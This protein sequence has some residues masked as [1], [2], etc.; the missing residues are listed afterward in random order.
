[1]TALSLA[2]KTVPM[3]TQGFPHLGKVTR[4]L[5]DNSVFIT[6]IRFKLVIFFQSKRMI[7]EEPLGIFIVKKDW[8]VLKTL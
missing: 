7:F 6:L 5:K 4:P 2:E 1:M 8:H 3:G